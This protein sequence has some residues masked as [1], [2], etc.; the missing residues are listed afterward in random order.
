MGLFE[1]KLDDT[2]HTDTFALGIV[3]ATPTLMIVS[4]RHAIFINAKTLAKIAVRRRPPCA[5]GLDQAAG[6]GVIWHMALMRTGWRAERDT[7]G[8]VRARVARA[9]G[10]LRGR[11]EPV[12]ASARSNLPG[13]Q[14]GR[15]VRQSARI[16]R[17]T[18][19]RALGPEGS[20]ADGH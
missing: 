14:Y 10:L 20:R 15:A 8:R 19:R 5:V 12:L 11:P 18:V 13:N 6:H 3:D 4:K 17:L 16:R 7:A 9:Y 1:Q 2:N